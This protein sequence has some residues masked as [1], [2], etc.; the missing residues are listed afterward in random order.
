[1]KKLLFL[2]L[3][4]YYTLASDQTPFT[5]PQDLTQWQSVSTE[6]MTPVLTTQDLKDKWQELL[7]LTMPIDGAFDPINTAR[8]EKTIVFTFQAFQD[9]PEHQRLDKLQGL[10]DRHQRYVKH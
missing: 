3:T 5:L 7:N 1:M 6:Y 8:R 4:T 10:I 2:A 9:I